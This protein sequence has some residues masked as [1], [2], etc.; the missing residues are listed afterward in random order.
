METKQY[1]HTPEALE[2]SRA[3]DGFTGWDVDTYASEHGWAGV[4]LMPVSRSRDAEALT[5]ANWDTAFN[6][7]KEYGTDTDTAYF[8]HALVGWVELATYNTGNTEL[9]KAVD[10]M[11]R[12]L[13]AYPVLSDDLWSE[14][15]WAENHPENS[16][17]CMSDDQNCTDWCGR[18]WAWA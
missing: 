18:K 12:D 13:E 5:R 16:D 4:G 10:S 3:Y 7:L 6:E 14:Y 15:E 2:S 1:T 11:R 9:S 17:E 8:G